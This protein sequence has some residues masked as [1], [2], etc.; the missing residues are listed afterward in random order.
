MKIDR[1]SKLFFWSSPVCI[2]FKWNV[3]T[4]HCIFT[5]F[6]SV[7]SSRVSVLYLNHSEGTTA[8][9]VLISEGKEICAELVYFWR[10][11]QNPFKGPEWPIYNDSFKCKQLAQNCASKSKRAYKTDQDGE[12][13]SNLKLGHP[14]GCRREGFDWSSRRSHRCTASAAERGAPR[15]SGR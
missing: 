12:S 15:L 10:C 4:E 3:Y 2:L 13:D 9:T 7:V 14:L 6:N 5:H 8:H 11:W 1:D